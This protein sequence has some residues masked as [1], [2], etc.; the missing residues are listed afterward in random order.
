MVAKIL[1]IDPCR[2]FST[3]VIQR[4]QLLRL[5]ERLL[6]R[7]RHPCPRHPLQSLPRALLKLRPATRQRQQQP[8]RSCSRERTA[9]HRAAQIIPASHQNRPM[10]TYRS[11]RPRLHKRPTHGSPRAGIIST[12]RLVREHRELLQQHHP[13][14]ISNK[15]SRSHSGSHAAREHRRVPWA[16]P[17]WMIARRAAAARLSNVSRRSLRIGWRQTVGR[18]SQTSRGPFPWRRSKIRMRTKLASQERPRCD[19]IRARQMTRLWSWREVRGNEH[20]LRQKF[21]PD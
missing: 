2:K 10:P 8:M 20:G 3:Q 5:E 1:E 17:T 14:R 15:G 12:F 4:Q 11:C 9:L 13:H 19:A 16:Y 6:R 21:L 7:A 18:F